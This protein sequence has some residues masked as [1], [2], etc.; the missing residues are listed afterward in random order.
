MDDYFYELRYH[1]DVDEW[2]AQAKRAMLHMA[3]KRYDHTRKGDS[4]RILDVGCGTGVTMSFL[5]SIGPV[6]GIDVS[7]LAVQF[8]R[9]RGLGNLAQAHGGMIPFKNG[10]FDMITAV[11]VMEHLEDDVGTLEEIYRVCASGGLIVVVVPAFQF[12]WS[13]RDERLHHRRRYTVSE[14]QARTE[15]AGFSIRKC[16]YVDLFLFAPLLLLVKLGLLSGKRPMLRMDVAPPVPVLDRCWLAAARLERLLL[17]WINFP[18]G[19]SVLCVGQKLP[20]P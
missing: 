12:L 18:L 17:R 5:A 2:R 19:V 20:D 8:C 10:S 11:D 13:N 1:N 14:I 4:I 16:S 3:W 7:S 9:K 6:W 15:Q